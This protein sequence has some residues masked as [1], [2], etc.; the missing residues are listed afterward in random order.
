MLCQYKDIF[1]KP[2][3]GVHSIRIFDIAVVDVLLTLFGAYLI[4]KIDLKIFEKTPL[5]V[6]FIYLILLSIVIHKLF[7]VDT[8]LTKTVFDR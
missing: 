6:I 2:K 7:C 8:K 3:E 1:G 4:K 5:L